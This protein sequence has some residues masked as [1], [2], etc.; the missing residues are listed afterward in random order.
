[1]DIAALGLSVDSSGVDK[2]VQSLDKLAAAAGKAEGASVSLGKAAERAAREQERAAARAAKAAERAAKEQLNNVEKAQRAATMRSTQLGYQLN[3]AFVQISSGQ[4]PLTTLIQQGSQI[5]PLYGG[6]TGTVRALGGAIAGMMTPIGVVGGGLAALGVGAAYGFMRWTDE[7]KALDASLQ[8][9]GR[10][11]GVTASALANLAASGA[12]TGGLSVSSGRDLAAAYAGAGLAGGNIETAIGLTK[13]FARVTGQDLGDA[14][15]N[16]A[17][18]LQDPTKGLET[19]NAALG[20]A[21]EKTRVLIKS[22]QAQGDAAGAQRALLAALGADLKDTTDRTGALSKA[23]D[24][25]KRG[26]SNTGTSLGSG[27]D[28]IVYGVA[29]QQRMDD[30]MRRRGELMRPSYAPGIQGNTQQAQ[31]Y[32]IWN[33]FGNDLTGAAAVRDVEQQIDALERRLDR[34]D[35]AAAGKM[36]TQALNQNS[37]LA[38]QSAYSI[39]PEL[40]RR[41]ALGDQIVLLEKAMNNPA[42]LDKMGMS[43]Q[44][45]STAL[46]GVR[47]AHAAILPLMEREAAAA[48][49]SLQAIKARTLA[50]RADVAYRQAMAGQKAGN[51][52]PAAE[53]KAR[54]DSDRVFAQGVMDAQERL[55][56]AND[57]AALAGLQSYQR[58]R[59]EIEQRY[60]RQSYLNRGSPDA[61]ADDA[62]V[63]QQELAALERNSITGPMA[64]ANRLLESQNRL[65]NVNAAT[66]G[67]STDRVVAAKTAQ[68]MFNRYIEAGIPITQQMRDAVLSYAE[69]MGKAGLAAEQLEEKQRN[70]VAGMDDLRSTSSSVF[71]SLMKGDTKGA[72]SAL[73]EKAMNSGADFLSDTLFGKK[74]KPGGGLFGDALGGLFSQSQGMD[75]NAGVVNVSGP[76]SGLG[77]IGG[78]GGV[79][80]APM[81][82]PG[83]GAAAGKVSAA[84]QYVGNGVDPRLT[85]IIAKASADSPYDVKLMSGYRQGDKR[86]HG[87]GLATDVQLIDRQTGKALPNY[88]DA[89]SFGAYEQFAQKAKSVQMRDYPGLNDN[90]RWGGYFGGEKG[91]YGALDTMHFDLGGRPGLGMAG[92]SWEKGLNPQQ[93]AYFPGARSQGMGDLGG[94]TRALEQF[95]ATTSSATTDLG[96]FGGGLGKM[97]SALFNSFTGQGGGGGGGLIGGLLGLLFGGLKFGGASAAASAT[98][99]MGGLY[100]SGGA[101]SGGAEIRVPTGF[102]MSRG[103][104]GLMGESGPEAVMPLSRDGSGRLG[105]RALAGRARPISQSNTLTVEGSTIVVQGSM[106]EVT[107]QRLKRDLDKRDQGLIARFE[108][109]FLVMNRRAAEQTG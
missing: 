8:G 12:A 21:D 104:M 39:L 109:S 95:Q 63:R 61:Q 70:V 58:S 2:G 76:V 52:D 72:L 20:F 57:N 78:T 14:G 41:R 85:D 64:D 10:R 33:D 62:Q 31:S 101:F 30:L 9:I 59:L 49:L 28:R 3:D 22:F 55:R 54:A 1:M 83:L 71:K 13:T 93:M 102:G 75:V 24:A 99:T 26:L 48:S 103:R 88:Q 96:T 7:Q 106:D 67:M 86:F 98:P 89:G 32:G 45:V 50:E 81:S 68:E 27:I 40:E 44:Q 105:V 29:D 80:S 34:A 60:A 73:G 37:G 79:G 82:L 92:G 17:K 16:L 4:S 25:F 42:M 46:D 11:A 53:I 47:A 108:Q 107:G 90:F 94:A 84:G 97:G 35:R 38:A 100:A 5:T 56:T 91:K 6:I 77:G 43:A 74:G 65:L 23:W 36:A 15:T 66:F 18:A 69:D 87:N 51:I 19:L